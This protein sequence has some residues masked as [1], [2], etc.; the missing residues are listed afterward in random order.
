MKPTRRSF[1]GF[2]AAAPVAVK[3]M[4]PEVL[5]SVE[6]YTLDKSYGSMATDCFPEPC[7]KGNGWKDEVTHLTKRLLD[8]ESEVAPL[9]SFQQRIV[10]FDAD[11]ASMR[12]LSLSARVSLQARRNREA[13]IEETKFSLTARLKHAKDMWLGKGET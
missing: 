3:E 13:S 6:P 12:S 11:I 10:K 2:L 4:L 7:T 9:K 5:Q 8:V 1:F